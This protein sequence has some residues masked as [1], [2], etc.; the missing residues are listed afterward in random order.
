[1]RAELAQSEAPAHW[2]G[3]SFFTPGRQ[4][5]VMLLD[6]AKLKHWDPD[7]DQEDLFA[8]RFDY[9]DWI[10]LKRE[11]PGTIGFLEP[12]RVEF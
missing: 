8:H 9:I 5:S 12:M 7:K 1:M 2:K 3:H 10:E 4:F 11:D 6:C